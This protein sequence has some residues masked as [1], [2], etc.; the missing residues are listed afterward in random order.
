MQGEQT[1][2]LRFC[3]VVGVLC[4]AL[5]W[6]QI[7]AQ[8]TQ[9]EKSIAAGTEAY[10]QGHYTEAEQFLLAALKQAKD[11]SEQDPRLATTLNNLAELYHAQ[12]KYTQ[13]E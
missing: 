5:L 7:L 8:D 12:G 11:F 4:G 9:W 3:R 6:T 1:T 10:E 13:A 2:N